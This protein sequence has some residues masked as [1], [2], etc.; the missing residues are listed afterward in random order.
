MVKALSFI[1][2]VTK[3][4]KDNGKMINGMVKAFSFMPTV[5]KCMKDNLKMARKN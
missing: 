3:C 2:T 5:T 4:I 1:V